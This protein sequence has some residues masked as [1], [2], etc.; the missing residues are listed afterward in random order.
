MSDPSKRTAWDACACAALHTPQLC[1]VEDV[2]D[3]EV[4]GSLPALNVFFGKTQIARY[5]FLGPNQEAAVKG[6]LA[7]L[8]SEV[9]GLVE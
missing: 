3:H 7:V 8:N 2:W 6:A 9:M 5:Q 1:A 4:A